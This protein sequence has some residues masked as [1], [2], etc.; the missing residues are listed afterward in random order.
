MTD[1]H[2]G[3]PVDDRQTDAQAGDGGR[4]QGG[5]HIRSCAAGSDPRRPA[6]RVAYE[7]ASEEIEHHQASLARV[8]K[9]RTLAQATVAEAMG[10]DKARSPALSGAPICCFPPCAAS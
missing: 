1:A 5:H 2:R 7:R 9:L 6:G 8:R 10:M 4:L 3:L